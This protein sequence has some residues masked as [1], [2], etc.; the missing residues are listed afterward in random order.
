MVDRG[1][2]R[3]P[4]RAAWQLAERR[5]VSSI[6]SRSLLHC[7]P[8]RASP[9]LSGHRLAPPL[10]MCAAL[11]RCAVLRLANPCRP[12]SNHPLRSKPLLSMLCLRRLAVPERAMLDRSMLVLSCRAHPCLSELCQPTPAVPFRSGLDCACARQANPRLPVRADHRAVEPCTSSPAETFAALPL[13]ACAGQCRPSLSSPIASPVV[14]VPA[15]PFA[16][17][18]GRSLA[19][20]AVPSLCPPTTI[21]TGLRLPCRTRTR[22]AFTIRS[23]PAVRRQSLPGLSV[24]TPALAYGRNS[25]GSLSSCGRGF[26]ATLT[27]KT[28]ISGSI[29]AASAKSR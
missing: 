12:C 22:L 21:T 25:G 29:M 18:P 3:C 17:V 19:M 13:R 24:H 23:V 10:L 7:L 26:G 27:R 1:R 15:S 11:P 14:A 4:A 8:R 2:R 9:D 20:P 16:S 5:E 28:S 6:I